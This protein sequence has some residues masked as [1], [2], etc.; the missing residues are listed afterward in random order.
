MVYKI[1]DK[2]VSI[3]LHTML[4]TVIHPTQTGFIR[5]RSILD[6]VYTFWKSAA[7][8]TK[9]KLTFTNVM[10]DFEKAYDHVYWDFCMVHWLGLVS[11]MSVLQVFPP[12]I[13]QHISRF[14]CQGT[15]AL[16]LPSHNQLDKG[17]LWLF[18]Y[19]FSLLRQ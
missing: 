13:A 18:S 8:A 3:R 19:F 2:L 15:M 11:L 12:Y 1:L 10:L 7:I 9:S 5:E 14:Y 6:N 17:S 16:S 4:P